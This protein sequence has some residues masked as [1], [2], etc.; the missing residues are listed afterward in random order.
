[1]P[2]GDDRRQHAQVESMV[3]ACASVCTLEWAAWP[4]V[5]SVHG[6]S[7]LQ[8]SPIAGTC[9]VAVCIASVWSASRLV[10]SCARPYSWPSE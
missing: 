3:G 4:G 7:L 9:V 5:L 1:M 10:V 2:Y 8:C 6:V